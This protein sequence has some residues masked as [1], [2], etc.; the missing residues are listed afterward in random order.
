MSVATLLT[1]TIDVEEQIV[2]VPYQTILFAQYAV[3]SWKQRQHVDSQPQLIMSK[4]HKI[5]DDVQGRGPQEP[6][7]LHVNTWELG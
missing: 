3:I 4:Q 7:S 5:R 1:A 2:L 6:K